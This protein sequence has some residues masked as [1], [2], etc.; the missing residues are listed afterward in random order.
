[1]NKIYLI[2]LL[3]IIICIIIYIFIKNK[4]SY[5]EKFSGLCNPGAICSNGS[6]FGIYSNVCDCIISG[7]SQSGLNGASD[8]GS[9][10]QDNYTLDPTLKPPVVEDESEGCISINQNLDSICKENGS[11]WGIK[12]IKRC[13]SSQNQVNLTCGNNYVNG[14]YM[15]N[16]S[17]TTPCLNKTDDFNTW[18][19]FY[20]TKNPPKGIS[21]NSIGAKNVY[22]GAY[23]A[24]YN[25]DGSS[26]NNVARAVCSYN[27]YESLDK[28]DYLTTGE[29]IDSPQIL[30]YNKFTECLPIQTGNFVSKCQGLLNSQ[31]SGSVNAINIMGY[32][33]NPGY[34][35]A[36]C[37]F[38]N[39]YKNGLY[40]N[41]V[42]KYAKSTSENAEQDDGCICEPFDN[43]DAG[44]ILQNMKNNMNQSKY[45]IFYKTEPVIKNEQCEISLNTL[46]P[47]DL[48]KL[49][50]EVRKDL[51]NT[52]IK[53]GYVMKSESEEMDLSFLKRK[54]DNNV[55]KYINSIDKWFAIPQN[56]YICRWKDLKINS[57]NNM[58]I[59]FWLNIKSINNN[60]YRNIFH[61]TNT[62]QNYGPNGCRV[63]ALWVSPKSTT[64]Y[65]SSDLDN[66]IDSVFT[67][68]SLTLNIP[69]FITITWLNNTVKVYFNGNLIKTYTHNSNIIP[70]NPDSFFYIGDPWHP[71]GDVEIKNFSIYNNALNQTQ[72]SYIYKAQNVITNKWTYDK[73]VVSWFPITQNNYIGTFG[74]LGIQSSINMSIA[75]GL[76]INTIFNLFRNIFHISNDN[77]DCCNSG[78]RVPALWV[79]PNNTNLLVAN[80]IQS[81]PN[82]FIKVDNKI[83]NSN[84]F[85]VITWNTRTVTVY[86]NGVQ[87]ITN[88]Y[89]SDFIIASS[90]AKVYIG[91]PW[92]KQDGGLK[93]RKFTIFNT[94]LNQD[95]VSKIYK[96]LFENNI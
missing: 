16:D 39:D 28:L 52:M 96:E 66:K 53:R 10:R 88:T 46:N 54:I 74:S 42:N 38:N 58:T 65:I 91:D 70:A 35:R 83:F 45:G 47:A 85:V 89:E 92:Y 17:F 50:N 93:I 43:N 20:N 31:V 48:K 41:L 4:Y 55:W 76:Q 68:S 60:S 44:T 71:S 94:T 57:N 51:K 1:M 30:D 19:Q 32:D 77:V 13:D 72:I 49:K 18:C 25:N 23:G 75:F 84:M 36:Q 2:L 14:K 5:V 81:L 87:V 59:S 15:G 26:N 62:N 6:N 61:F 63:P 67:T 9:S 29:D 79:Y 78:N 37:I 90:D 21:K 24:C 40:S 64:L 3:F 73:S 8:T 11:T 27:N 80:D 7:S 95:Q 69:T 12:N 34:A 56:N 33:C 86:I 22:I 82:Q